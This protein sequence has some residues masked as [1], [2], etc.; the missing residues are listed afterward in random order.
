MSLRD[1]LIE[2]LHAA[3]IPITLKSDAVTIELDDQDYRV[4]IRFEPS[5]PDAIEGVY[6]INDGDPRRDSD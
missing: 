1:K 3:R 6:V 5:D 4:R 2:A